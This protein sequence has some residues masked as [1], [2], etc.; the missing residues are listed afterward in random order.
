MVSFAYVN[1]LI[2]F[3][4]PRTLQFVIATLL[5]QR[6]R[7]IYAEVFPESISTGGPAGG[8]QEEVI[9][10]EPWLPDKPK[11]FPSIIGGGTQNVSDQENLHRNNMRGS[12]LATSMSNGFHNSSTMSETKES[13][14]IP[15]SDVVSPTGMFARHSQQQRNDTQINESLSN[16]L[17][18]DPK[19]SKKFT[20]RSFHSLT[21]GVDR[22]DY[23]W[24]LRNSVRLEDYESLGK[25]KRRRS[26]MVKFVKTIQ[27]VC[28]GFDEDEDRKS[29]V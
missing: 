16:S 18:F 5:Q 10:S 3:I 28:E 26:S 19:A 29:V 1:F 20:S 25:S 7:E 27:D 21:G 22:S 11:R 15:E 14:D 12:V 23:E 17:N 8:R 6:S 13:A 4:S 24:R 2:K 9:G